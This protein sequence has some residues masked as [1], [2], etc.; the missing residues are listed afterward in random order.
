MMCILCKCLILV[1]NFKFIFYG[2]V[3][4]LFP[5]YGTVQVAFVSST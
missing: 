4:A 5:S 3:C 2:A 1:V